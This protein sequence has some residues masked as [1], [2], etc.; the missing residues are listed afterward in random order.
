[1]NPSPPNPAH[2]WKV[3]TYGLS[4]SRGSG[5]G[6][7]LENEAN[8]V[9]EVSLCFK[10]YATNNKVE[11][12]AVIVGITLAVEMEEKNIKLRIYSH[13]VVSQVK[14][15]ACVKGP[16]VQQFLRLTK[17]KLAKF[18]M[19]EVAHVPREENT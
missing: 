8:L 2:T 16:L 4:N 7:I 14:G 17:V 5:A 1:M 10:F 15:E 19:F 13:L 9:V 18:K 6:V 12:E 3:F 11:S